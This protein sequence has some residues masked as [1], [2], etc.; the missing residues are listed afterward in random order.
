M[1]SGSHIFRPSFP[2]FFPQVLR[3]DPMLRL[4]L[5]SIRPSRYVTYDAIY[6]LLVWKRLKQLEFFLR[7]IRDGKS[8]L[9]CLSCFFSDGIETAFGPPFV[10]P[11]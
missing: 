11:S 6:L 5:S 3:Y 4:E 9:F 7:M 10:F 1:L 2:S 8:D